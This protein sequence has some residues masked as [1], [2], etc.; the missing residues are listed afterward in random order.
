VL[1]VT[2]L[3]SPHEFLQIV[4]V[5]LG[6]QSV[7]TIRFLQLLFEPSPRVLDVL[8]VDS[9]IDEINRMVDGKVLM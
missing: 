5:T 9:R 4:G 6:A 7:K 2:E 3:L 1:A 8:R